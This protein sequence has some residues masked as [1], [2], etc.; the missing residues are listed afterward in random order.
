MEYIS[1]ILA[2]VLVNNIVLT[3]IFGINPTIAASNSIE[4]SVTMGFAITLIMTIASIV[5]KLVNDYLLINTQFLQ[6]IVFVIIIALVIE[7][8][9]LVI[10]NTS[11]EK[12]DSIKTVVPLVS[13]NSLILGVSL[14]VV[15]NGFTLLETIAYSVGV[16]LGFTLLLLIV[17]A[18]NN[19]YRFANMPKN[20]LE[21]PIT[22]F[23]LGLIALAFYGFKGLF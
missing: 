13:S 19:K 7:L 20:F 22:F 18:I 11:N 2:A 5:T 23:A 21:K 14:L 9:Y 3:Q 12:F 8:C 1:I 15:Q 16:G 10:K 4:S 17:S 6:V